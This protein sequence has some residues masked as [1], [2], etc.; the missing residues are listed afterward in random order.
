MN[1]FYWLG[2]IMLFSPSLMAQDSL[3]QKVQ[4]KY[5]NQVSRKADKI[6]NL[7][8]NKSAKQLA[9]LAKQEARM[10][11]KMDEINPEKS[12]S[13]FGQSKQKIES[14]KAKLLQKA[15]GATGGISGEYNSYLDT[16]QASVKFLNSAN[17]I[18]SKQ[19]QNSIVALQSKFQQSEEIENYIRTRRKELQQQLGQYAS[20]TTDLQNLNKQAYYYSAQVNEYKKILEDRDKT[21]VKAMEL[22]R[23]LP[24]FQKFF[25]HNSVIAGMF[26]LNRS[27]NI[28]QDLEGLQQRAVVE[29]MVQDRA[30]TDPVARQALSQQLNQAAEQ[31]NKITDKFPSLKNSGD[32]PEFKPNPMR[33]KRTIDRIKLGGNFNFD[34]NK[35]MVPKMGNFAVQAAYEFNPKISVGLGVAYRL[36]INT[37]NKIRFTNEGVGFRSFFDYQ[38]RNIFYANAGFELNHFS[39]FSGVQD[40]KH[41][42]GFQK[43]ALAGITTKVKVTSKYKST[44]QLAYDFLATR[45]APFA[46]PLILRL[47][48][49]K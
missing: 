19:V 29:Q 8:A 36:G 37:V 5:L 45:Q 47:G 48:F 32:V 46:S 16:M 28:T 18:G 9:W 41:W 38:L 2:L 49:T 23:K 24:A 44:M 40:L 11:S 31:F 26:N 10:Q 33:T 6:N 14:L 43:T 15:S 12:N 1:Q 7:I 3:T 42:N 34:R 17:D 22:L 13:I 4:E 21:Q 35:Y 25:D 20:F 39:G 27:G 30:G